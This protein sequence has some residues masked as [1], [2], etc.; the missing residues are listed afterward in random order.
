MEGPDHQEGVVDRVYTEGGSE[1]NRRNVKGL[2]WGQDRK[3]A[4]P[5]LIIN[6]K[7]N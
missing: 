2:P 5:V 3:E 7:I 1:R 4:E 6:P